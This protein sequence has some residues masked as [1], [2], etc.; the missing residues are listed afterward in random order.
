VPCFG[1]S[2]CYADLKAAALNGGRD[3]LSAEELEFVG[4]GASRRRDTSDGWHQAGSLAGLI[5]DHLSAEDAAMLAALM[6]VD[7]PARERL[8]FLG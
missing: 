7:V 6:E 4:L 8:E 3:K 1:L 5:G 2:A